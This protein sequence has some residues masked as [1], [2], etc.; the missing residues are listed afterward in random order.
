MRR[1]AF[2]KNIKKHLTTY[3]EYS[4]ETLGFSEAWPLLI[5]GLSC[6]VLVTILTIFLYLKYIVFDR[7]STNFAIT[8]V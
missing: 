7:N 5:F 8:N 6:M 1:K 4:D 2:R 3:M